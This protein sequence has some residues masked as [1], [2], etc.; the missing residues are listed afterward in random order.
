M[1]DNGKVEGS[2]RK[3]AEGNLTSQQ[4]VHNK[5]ELLQTW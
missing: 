3:E 4:L 1:E 2:V 5:I